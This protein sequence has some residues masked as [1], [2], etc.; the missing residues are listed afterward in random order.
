MD[1]LGPGA[2]S[3]Y[4][5]WGGPAAVAQPSAA[6]HYHR[7][8]SA[9]GGPTKRDVAVPA[10]A[11]GGGSQSSSAPGPS[12]GL[13]AGSPDDGGGFHA[14][15]GP[16]RRRRD[17][18][19][20]G[21]PRR[22]TPLDPLLKHLRREYGS[23]AGPTDVLA[24]R[25]SPS[26]AAEVEEILASSGSSLAS[27][28]RA[29]LVRSIAEGGGNTDQGSVVGKEIRANPPGEP[30]HRDHQRDQRDHHAQQPPPLPHLDR[31]ATPLASGGGVPV[32]RPHAPSYASTHDSSYSPDEV[33]E[34]DSR[35]SRRRGGGRTMP[36]FCHSP[37][38]HVDGL[39]RDTPRLR[40]LSPGSAASAEDREGGRGRR[41][42]FLGGL[43]GRRDDDD[44]TSSSPHRV[45]PDIRSSILRARSNASASSELASFITLL[46]N[47]MSQERFAGV[48]SE[49][50][51][52][53]FALVQSRGT[54]ADD[55]LAGVAAIDA[56]VGV[57]SSDESYR[58]VRFG[59]SLS[60]GEFSTVAVFYGAL[61]R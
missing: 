45:T 3:G 43:L 31:S 42:N 53:V 5:G 26:L 25:V 38:S 21:G 51:S 11:G 36:H 44:G 8:G 49:V 30:Q 22:P 2:R 23:S 52:R 46:S 33:D 32:S 48:E 57:P 40:H 4:H 55:R 50:Y 39:L 61:G 20:D 16:S 1:F 17:G 7:S 6:D 10:A 37:P 18:G 60:N 12:P 54:G 14:F 19:R 13:A 34:D 15:P 29:T 56:L 24:S 28:R 27:R 58:A 35:E 41:G 47:E 59:N 9:G